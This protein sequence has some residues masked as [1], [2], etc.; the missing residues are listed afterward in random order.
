MAWGV[1]MKPE[2]LVNFELFAFFILGVV[3]IVKWVLIKDS[4][5]GI[6]FLN[7]ALKGMTVLLLVSILGILNTF[8]IKTVK[9]KKTETKEEANKNNENN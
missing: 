5:L 7:T 8:W 9:E 6:I 4:V 1:Q 2:T 3:I